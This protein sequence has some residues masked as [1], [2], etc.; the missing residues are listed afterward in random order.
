MTLQEAARQMFLGG[1]ILSSQHND[2]AKHYRRIKN[3]KLSGGATTTQTQNNQ[4]PLDLRWLPG[5][6]QDQMRGRALAVGQTEDVS[7]EF[8]SSE[9][10]AAIDRRAASDDPWWLVQD[11]TT[12]EEDE[13][14][15]NHD[16]VSRSDPVTKNIHAGYVMSALLVCTRAPLP[17][18]SLVF[19]MLGALYMPFE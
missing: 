13:E 11:D 2:D 10:L 4:R 14:T 18:A 8:S 9:A 6:L 12:D 16:E 5:D 7:K 3:Y 1:N 19:A 15:P 17:M